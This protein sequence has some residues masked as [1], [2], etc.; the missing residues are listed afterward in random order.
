MTTVHAISLI[1]F[2]KVATSLKPTHVIV[3]PLPLS[4]II[5]VITS[6]EDLILNGENACDEPDGLPT[7][8]TLPALTGAL[9]LHVCASAT[10]ILGKI[11]DIP[12]GL[13]FREFESLCLTCNVD[14][15][16]LSVPVSVHQ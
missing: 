6:F 13:H 4:K 15:E 11:W 14:G 5:S 7:A 9:R 2:D 10:R 12:S 3:T 16:L 1:P 8:R